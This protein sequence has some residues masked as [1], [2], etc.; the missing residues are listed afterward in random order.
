MVC[1]TFQK[2]ERWIFIESH[3]DIC[4]ENELRLPICRMARR[5]VGLNVIQ[6]YGLPIQ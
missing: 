6:K 3:F 5:S 4:M 1:D 2:E